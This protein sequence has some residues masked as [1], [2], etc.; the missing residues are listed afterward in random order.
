MIHENRSEL[1][2]QRL[3]AAAVEADESPA[4]QLFV[5]VSGAPVA[6]NQT[7]RR[8][9]AESKIASWHDLFLESEVQRWESVL[10]S[11][12]SQQI[13]ISECFE[14]RRFDKAT[15]R[16]VLRAE[17][18]YSSYGVFL[19][20]IVSGMDISDLQ[21][22]TTS[23]IEVS[24]QRQVEGL[25]AAAATWHDELVSIATVIAAC[26]DMLPDIIHIPQHGKSTIEVGAV[27]MKLQTA[28]G[29]LRD[30]VSELSS[31]SRASDNAAHLLDA[32]R[33]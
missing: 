24:D 3:T 19:G 26:V 21:P 6:F 13:P 10:I 5:D 33:A 18:K 7:A 14:L 16:F 2:D 23:P 11:S 4:L 28:S 29:L 17:P 12:A 25:G 20:Q 1:D 8:F 27:L 31:V 9:I 22:V 30:T 32:K 15:R